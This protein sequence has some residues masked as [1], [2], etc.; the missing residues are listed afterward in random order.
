MNVSVELQN[1]FEFSLNNV[2]QFVG[3]LN[4]VEACWNKTFSSKFQNICW[5]STQSAWFHRKNSNQTWLERTYFLSNLRKTKFRMIWQQ[6]HCFAKELKA[7]VKLSLSP[8][9]FLQTFWTTSTKRT[10][11]RCKCFPRSTSWFIKVKLKAQFF[12]VFTRQ[13]LF[14]VRTS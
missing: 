4:N 8:K 1:S 2:L 10:M 7:G 5:L 12:W 13:E 14:K 3:K 6:K 11:S 9:M